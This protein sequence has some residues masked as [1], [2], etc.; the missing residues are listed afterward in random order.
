MLAVAPF[1]AALVR[2]G[3]E[4]LAAVP[5]D[6][7]AMARRARLE[8]WVLEDVTREQV[9][10][11]FSSLPSDRPGDARR[12]LGRELY[13]RLHIPAALPGMRAVIGRF[14][15]D[16]VLRETFHY[17]SALAAEE[18]GVPHVR[19]AP[20]MAAV[21]AAAAAIAAEGSPGLADAV[22]AIGRSP[23]LTLAPASFDGPD[24]PAVIRRYRQVLV[25]EQLAEAERSWLEAAGAPL[26]YVT[27][28]SVAAGSRSFPALMR[29]ALAA[30]ARLEVRALATVGERAD[31][32]QFGHPPSNVRVARW[33]PQAQVLGRA[34]AMLATAASGPCSVACT[35][36]CRWSWCRCSPINRA[37]PRESRPSAP[38]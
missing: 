6:S 9:G 12:M 19:V 22:A 21:D 3:H 29:S 5:S 15:P 20:G 13:G 11:V 26:V 7:V 33:V 28:G 16:L 2:S 1:A 32:T 17:A 27:F 4:V 36:V 37:T 8:C 31:P 35:P 24:P 34:A 14:G 30:L 10:R 23:L 38:A 25:P 18:E